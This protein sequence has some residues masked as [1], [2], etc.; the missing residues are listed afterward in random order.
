MKLFWRSKVKRV[1]TSPSSFLVTFLALLVAVSAGGKNMTLS[2]G[3]IVIC[4]AFVVLIVQ[5][6]LE[7]KKRTYDPSLALKYL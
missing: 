3:T 4:L 2:L 6:W 1:F 7:Y 5:S